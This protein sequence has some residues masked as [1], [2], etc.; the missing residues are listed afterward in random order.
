MVNNSPFVPTIDNIEAATHI[1]VVHE[2]ESYTFAL[3]ESG[4]S[5]DVW[6]DIVAG[7]TAASYVSDTGTMSF[8]ALMDGLS[9]NPE[10]LE[11]LQSSAPGV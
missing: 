4:K 1:K 3:A 5:N 8:S 7:T 9:I 6:V 10:L 11:E 2:G